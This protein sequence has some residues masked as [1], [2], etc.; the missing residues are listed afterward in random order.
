MDEQDIVYYHKDDLTQ[1]SKHLGINKVRRRDGNPLKLSEEDLSENG[2]NNG[3]N[4][5]VD[6]LF[7]SAISEVGEDTSER[8]GDEQLFNG[9]DGGSGDKNMNLGP[10]DFHDPNG[11]FGPGGALGLNISTRDNNGG[12]GPDGGYG[13]GG[14]RKGGKYGENG[15]YSG[16]ENDG[17][18]KKGKRRRK[19]SKKNKNPK[20]T[21]QQLEKLR[22]MNAIYGAD[23]EELGLSPRD[24]RYY[25]PKASGRKRIMKRD[26]NQ[27][28]MPGSGLDDG[29]G[30]IGDGKSRKR[31][32]KN[33]KIK[34][35]DGSDSVDNINTNRFNKLKIN[36]PKRE[37]GEYDKLKKKLA[38]FRKRKDLSFWIN[39][40]SPYAEYLP[41]RFREWVPETKLGID[42]DE[43]KQAMNAMGKA[44]EL[45][46]IYSRGLSPDEENNP[47]RSPS[48]ERNPGLFSNQ[49][50]PSSMFRPNS[51]ASI[52]I[53][54]VSK[55]SSG[56]PSREKQTSNK[57]KNTGRMHERP[58]GHLNVYNN[59]LDP[60]DARKE[61][62][63]ALN[64]ETARS[65]NDFNIGPV[66]SN[67]AYLNGNDEENK[68]QK[69]TDDDEID[70]RPVTFNKF[71]A[72]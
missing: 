12:Y 25:D 4:L 49:K 66:Y 48:D 55:I 71:F 33:R 61:S 17:D 19:K 42:L 3:S 34:T 36:K 62:T 41:H 10:G 6:P 67:E 65:N 23:A 57:K 30:G 54:S 38:K 31:S 11:I 53:E 27:S 7:R 13:P 43:N 22:A 44:H 26:G 16:D 20:L 60:Q 2:S 8:F 68:Y 69:A 9:I 40:D 52:G 50:Q 51:N 64:E 28:A 37:E 46:R 21:Q 14:K 59:F 35:Q 47:N 58:P 18:G 24:K 39:Y 15:E 32:R 29:L 45:S 70:F 72:E 56:R 5:M 1:F 63:D